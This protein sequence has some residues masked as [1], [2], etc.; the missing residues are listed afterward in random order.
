MKMTLPCIA[1]DIQG[2]SIRIQQGYRKG[3]GDLKADILYI[4]DIREKD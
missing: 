2:K 4:D 1:G 3:R